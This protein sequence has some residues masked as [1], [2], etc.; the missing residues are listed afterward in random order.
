[1]DCEMPQQIGLD[2]TRAIRKLE[3]DGLRVGAPRTPVIAM[4]ASALLGD[5][6]KCL[7]AGI[8]DFMS[9]PLRLS[10]LNRCCGTGL[11]P[12]RRLGRNALQPGREKGGEK[13]RETAPEGLPG[14]NN[15]VPCSWWLGE[16]VAVHFFSG[17]DMSAWLLQQKKQHPKSLP[18][19][20]FG[21]RVAKSLA[22]WTIKGP[23]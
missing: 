6:E 17:E 3:A 7:A 1:M 4:T 16:N 14:V 13:N 22:F 11:P 10:Q 2:A 18:R 15:S 19:T 23:K 9:K 20:L 21:E 12:A 8:D 5:P